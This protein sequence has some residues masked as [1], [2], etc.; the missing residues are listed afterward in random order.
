MGEDEYELISRQ[1]LGRLRMIEQAGPTAGS[2]PGTPAQKGGIFEQLDPAL[3]TSLNTSLDKL[4]SSLSRLLILFERAQKEVAE[5]PEVP[6]N[7]RLESQNEKIASGIVAVA[8]MIRDQQIQI[9]QLNILFKGIQDKMD[10]LRLQRRPTAA[11]KISPSLL[12]Q[13]EKRAYGPLEP[14]SRQIEIDIP[15]SP[16]KEILEEEKHENYQT[17]S[18]F[19]Q[20]PAP[21]IPRPAETRE[22]ISIPED[23]P[24]PPEKKGI[25][26]FLKK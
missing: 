3:I 17:L 23:L 11:F 13:E 7:E 14:E 18:M 10:E 8:N 2:P 21:P 19:S 20:I 24:P 4:N 26:K 25:L 6:D 12:E 5:K 9:N 16:A 15:R 22:A 1:E